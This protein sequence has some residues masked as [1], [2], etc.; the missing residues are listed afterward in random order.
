M[1]NTHTNHITT[2]VQHVNRN[3][4][5]IMPTIWHGWEVFKR[6]WK[7]ILTVFF[8]Y[9]VAALPLTIIDGIWQ[10]RLYTDGVVFDE[11]LQEEIMQPVWTAGTSE[12]ILYIIFAIIMFAWSMVVGYNWYKSFY[13]VY[14]G[15]SYEFKD[16][17]KIPENKTWSNF[18]NYYVATLLYCLMVMFGFILL[19]IPG[20]YLA[21][22]Y[23]QTMNL[24][25][26]KNFRIK[27]A[28]AMSTKMTE[29]IK[30]KLLGFGL[31]QGLFVLGLILAGLVALLVGVIPAMFV[32][33]S[34]VMMNNIG[35]Y[36]KLYNANK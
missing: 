18:F 35:L 30:W 33:F 5:A 14:D 36:R 22:R 19:I 27:E 16:M 32:A 10:T 11:W 21:I 29:G 17:F 2:G 26:D 1:E 4:F 31:T 6:E 15:D 7:N 12:T 24:I 9:V 34:W 3:H 20:I 8:A 23:G 13:R 28:F 25:L